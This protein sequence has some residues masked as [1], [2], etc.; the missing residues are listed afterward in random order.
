MSPF[1]FEVW[2]S[3]LPLLLIAATFTW[4]LSLPLRNVAIVDSLWSLMLFAA[5][6]MYGLSADPRAPRLAFVLWLL[7]LWAARLSIYVTARSMGK[8]ED[9]RYRAIRARNEPNFKWKSLYLV[10]WLQ[11]LLAWI[12]SLPLLGVFAGNQPLGTLDYLGIGLWLVGFTFEAVGDWQLARFRKDPA[13]AGSVMNRGLWRY[14]RHPNYFGEFCVWWGFWLIAL[15]AGAWW[16]VAGPALL[17]FLLLRVSGVRLLEKD[18]GNRR[19]Q[20]ADY[21]LKTNAFFP[22]PPRK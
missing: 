10:F 17:T 16:S 8:G 11:A 2:L 9:H 13:N 21:V 1:D 7:V 22:G 12:I 5:G 19:P 14:T 20:Y 6:V 15:A 3:A 18:I 4:L